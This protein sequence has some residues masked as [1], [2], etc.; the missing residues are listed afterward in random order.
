MPCCLVDTVSPVPDA[1]NMSSP[2]DTLVMASCLGL[3]MWVIRP[4]RLV[5]LEDEYGVV[6][7]LVEVKWQD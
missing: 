6:A 1:M 4:V 7:L 3:P 5:M 2:T